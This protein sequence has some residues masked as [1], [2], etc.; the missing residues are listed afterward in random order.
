MSRRDELLNQI[1]TTTN[2]SRDILVEYVKVMGQDAKSLEHNDLLSLGGA[3]QFRDP[4]TPGEKIATSI[5]HALISQEKVNWE[6]DPKLAH[7]EA[8][9]TELTDRTDD[10]K[11][12]QELFDRIEKL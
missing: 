2:A 7:I 3:A 1:L 6:D 5:Q 10:Q 12:W 11:L 4:T 9:A 8:I